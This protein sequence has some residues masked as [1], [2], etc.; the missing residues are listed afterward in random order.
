[1]RCQCCTTRTTSRVTVSLDNT[2]NLLGSN[3]HPA[4]S[5]SNVTFFVAFN[6]GANICHDVPHKPSQTAE[7]DASLSVCLVQL[8]ASHHFVLGNAQNCS[9]SIMMTNK[10][11]LSHKACKRTDTILSNIT[12]SNFLSHLRH[13]LSPSS[14]SSSEFT[15]FS[16]VTNSHVVHDLCCKLGKPAEKRTVICHAHTCVMFSWD[17]ECSASS[18][19]FSYNHF[20]TT[21][22][23]EITL[24][25]SLWNHFHSRARITAS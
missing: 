1:M 8:F 6:S 17:P 23:H 5:L 25:W 22:A 2:W 10:D 16:L 4:P 11:S 7:C 18:C 20:H 24:T 15:C 12:E 9:C 14:S 19:H 21:V 3:G 13:W